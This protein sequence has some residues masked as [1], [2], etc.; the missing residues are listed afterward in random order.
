MTSNMFVFYLA[1]LLYAGLLP[2][3]LVAVGVG[4]ALGPAGV[5][6]VPLGEARQAEAGPGA[7]VRPALGVGAARVRVAGRGRRSLLRRALQERVALV[8]REAGADHVAG[9]HVA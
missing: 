7:P 3:V 8:A 6:R 1:L 9:D 2:A 4:D 5:V